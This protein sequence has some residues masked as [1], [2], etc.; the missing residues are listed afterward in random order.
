MP[1]GCWIELFETPDFTGE[2]RRFYGPTLLD[3]FVWARFRPADRISFRVGPAAVARVIGRDGTEA[4]VGPCGTVRDCQAQSF[5]SFEIGR[6]EEA[7]A[8]CGPEEEE[9][10]IVLRTVD[11]PSPTP[12]RPK[13]RAPQR[14]AGREFEAAR[15]ID[16]AAQP[17]SE[18][19]LDDGTASA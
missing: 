6:A 11:D 8:D 10:P 9:R 19:E 14:D 12:I 3:A 15:E 7:C 17:D 13:R 1:Q 5:A 2:R 4:N 16:A 18:R